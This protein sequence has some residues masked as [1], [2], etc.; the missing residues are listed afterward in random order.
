MLDKF[1]DKL[2]KKA[3]VSLW[4]QLRK[5]A[6]L[7][8]LIVICVNARFIAAVVGI[9]ENDAGEILIVKHTYKKYPW[10]LPSGGMRK[11]NPCDALKREIMEETGFEIEPSEV[12]NVYYSRSPSCLTVVIRAKLIGGAFRPCAEISEHRFVSP[13]DI[14][15]LPAKQ[16]EMIVRMKK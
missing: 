10:G 7:R 4:R 16:R 12:L 9:V 13:D 14:A 3:V 6:F 2:P 5:I 8:N 11:E 15:D 1:I